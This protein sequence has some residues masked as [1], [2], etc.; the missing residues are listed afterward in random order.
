MKVLA[1]IPA[2]MGSQRLK[3][4]NLKEL[5]GIPLI[6]HAIRKC[7]A[8]DLF[9]EVWVNSES[10]RIKDIANEEN[11]YFH[12]RPN[13]LA[14]NQSTS[15]DYI[16]EF[17]LKHSCDI[18]VQVHTIAPLLSQT[19]IIEFTNYMLKNDYDT[20]LSVEDIFLECVYKGNPIN[21]RKNSKKKFSRA[22]PCPKNF[23]EYHFLAFR[24]LFKGKRGRKVCYFFRKSGLFFN[25]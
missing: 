18:I 25:Q 21:F 12:P 16:H 24:C 11:V 4:K 19:N 7:K 8:I 14:N 13:E 22:Q 17:L 3:E 10:L 23:L 1:I 9:D 6:V 2:R 15:E 20:L 5:A